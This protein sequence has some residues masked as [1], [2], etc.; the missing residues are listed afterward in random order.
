MYMGADIQYLA[1]LADGC[2][3]SGTVIHS[4][5]MMELMSQLTLEDLKSALYS[6]YTHVSNVPWPGRVRVHV[7]AL[8][9]VDSA[10]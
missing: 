4:T 9:C 7:N 6:N 5:G 8:E 10:K 3:S 2:S 1:L